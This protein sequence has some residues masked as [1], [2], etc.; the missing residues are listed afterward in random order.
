LLESGL[1]GGQ[2]GARFLGDAVHPAGA[3]VKVVGKNIF[4]NPLYAIKS[5][6]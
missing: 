5:T 3:S 4:I 6:A 1:D 2:F